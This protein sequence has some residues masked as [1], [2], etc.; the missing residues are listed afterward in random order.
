MTMELL[1]L[2]NGR[3]KVIKAESTNQVMPKIRIAFG[4]ET[5]EFCIE[6][7]DKSW[8]WCEVDSEDLKDRQEIRVRLTKSPAQET[9]FLSEKDTR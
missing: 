2:H 7:Y 1:V 6:V 3:R 9:K 4:L 5:D 8:N